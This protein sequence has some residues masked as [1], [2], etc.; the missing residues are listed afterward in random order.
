MFLLRADYYNVYL[1]NANQDHV[2]AG[3]EMSRAAVPDPHSSEAD[4]STLRFDGKKTRS[5]PFP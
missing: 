1:L 5:D 4:T 2:R 3:Q